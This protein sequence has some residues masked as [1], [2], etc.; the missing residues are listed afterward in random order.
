MFDFQKEERINRERTKRL[1]SWYKG[2]PQGPVQIDVELHKRCNLNCIFCSRHTIHEKLNRE[3][4]KHEMSVERWLGIVTEAKKIDAL[5]FNIEGINEP[6]MVPELLFPFMEKIKELGMYGIITTNGTLWNSQR[7]KRI[8][9]IGWDRIHFSVHSPTPKIHDYL[10]GMSGAWK[11][12]IQ[13]IKTLNEWKKRFDSQRPMLNINICVNILNYEKLPEMVE[14][15]HRLEADYIFTEPL[16]VFSDEGR[17]LKLSK[18]DQTNLSSILKIARKLSEKYGIDN[19]F[20]TEDKNLE[21]EIV[22]SASKMQPL[23][24]ADVQASDDGLIS[25]PCFKPWDRIAIRYTG[26]TGHC[27]FIEEGEDVKEKN[28]KEIW[29][30]E[31][32]QTVRKRM[33][34][35]QLFPHCSKCVPSDLTQRRRF[36]R[37]LIRAIRG[38]VH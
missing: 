36:R 18:N 5:V 37:E 15:A 6:P 11:R 3:S 38:D 31:F 1:A 34:N 17:K 19:N 16:M 27:G 24:L 13:A 30:G 7:L 8:V 28:L 33:I 32:F 23:L 35:K 20:A 29:Y 12:A 21:K 9:E 22:E 26:L 14:L 2:R 10:V 25:A 4:P